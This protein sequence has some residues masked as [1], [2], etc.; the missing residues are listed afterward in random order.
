MRLKIQERRNGDATILELTGHLVFGPESETLHKHVKKLL[1]EG[2]KKIVLHLESVNHVDS[3]GIGTLV[4]AVKSARS[5]NGKIHFLKLSP[6]VQEAF[7]LVGF[8][9]RPDLI[10]VFTDEQEAVTRF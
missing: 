4:A 2:Q 9:V 8:G 1:G 10:P 3:I 7:D 6:N 5:T